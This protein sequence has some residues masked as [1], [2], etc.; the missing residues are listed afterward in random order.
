MNTSL[1][2]KTNDYQEIADT[3]KNSITCG[4]GEKGGVGKTFFL[5][6]LLQFAEIKGW[7]KMLC[8]VDAEPSIA[9]IS[10]IYKEH[11]K[12]VFSDSKF[13]FDRPNLIL[14]KVE[15][16]SVV[17]NLPSSV[18]TRFDDW[19]A[20]LDML[21]DTKK[22]YH[23]IVYYYV[24]DGCAGSINYFTKHVE[25]YGNTNMK[26]CLVLNPGRC[27]TAR[28]FRYLEKDNGFIK[29]IQEAKVPIICLPELGSRHQYPI[30]KS[31]KSYKEYL[32]TE[33]LNISEKRTI[34]QFIEQSNGLFDK[35]YPN[36]IS[37]A[38]GLPQ[39]AEEQAE[40]RKQGKILV[41]QVEDRNRLRKLF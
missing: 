26:T 31:S 12:V 7:R 10:R 8:L 9:D 38:E 4:G 30:E 18:A 23:E 39:I 16:K 6:L 28:D 37:F 5:K 34:S 11:E 32:D 3:S 14:D 41:G 21:G 22:Y 25:R 17:V 33:K 1:R 35:I 13:D 27:S 2:D 20:R 40:D 15:E 29:V 19:I 36:R 24:T